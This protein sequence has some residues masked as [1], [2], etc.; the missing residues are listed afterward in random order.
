MPLAWQAARWLNECDGYF[1]AVASVRSAWTSMA[2]ALGLPVDGEAGMKL[3]RRSMA[4]ELRKPG[5]AVP[6]EELEMMLCHRK[7]DRVTEL[8]APFD[9]AYPGNAKTA[10]EAIIDEIEADVPGAF[11]RRDTGAGAAIIPIKAAKSA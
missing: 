10:I 2:V 3:I 7:L 1:V 4:H 8:Y 9:P 6:R 11:D 5:R